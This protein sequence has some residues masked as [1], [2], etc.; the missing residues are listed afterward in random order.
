M[1][2]ETPRF[3]VGYRYGNTASPTWSETITQTT[4]G[5]EDRNRNW[6]FSKMVYQI[7]MGPNMADDILEAYEFWMALAGPDV[8][9]R[10]KDWVDYKSCRTTQNAAA[11]DQ[12]LIF[13][14]GSPGG[15]W[16]ITKQYVKGAQA[17]Q[18]TILKP[19]QGTIQ[20]ADVI[21]GVA[22]LKTE[23]THYVIDYTSGLV[24]VFFSP[25]GTL[26]W[27]GEF[28]VPV[29]FDSDFPV[30]VV[31][32]GN[33]NKQIATVQFQLRELPNPQEDD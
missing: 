17:T 3:P 33:A 28:D 9:F 8:G 27:G 31:A 14:P 5:F 23:G 7:V 6:Q 4:S 10:F 19:V 15:G 30:Q 24:S 11:T 21:A 12:P 2:L 1:F 25:G 26:T 22:H 18:R 20:I 16:Q 13:I 32:Q 29:R